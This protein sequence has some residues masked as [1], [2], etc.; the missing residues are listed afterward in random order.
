MSSQGFNSTVYSGFTTTN[1]AT[2]IRPAFPLRDASD[3]VRMLKRRSTY[4]E[5]KS[6]DPFNGK[7]SPYYPIKQSNDLRLDNAFGKIHCGGCTGGGF[8]IP[9]IST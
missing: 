4:R 2:G 9:P 1:D 5:N 6:G 7:V 3:Y 8:S